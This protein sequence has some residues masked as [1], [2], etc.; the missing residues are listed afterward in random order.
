MHPSSR[1]IMNVKALALSLILI[2]VPLSGC[3]GGNG[4]VNV[5]LEPE[6]IQELID[7]NLDDFLNNTTVTINQNYTTDVATL[8]V[9]SGTMQ[10]IETTNNFVEGLSILVRGD[11]YDSASAGNSAAGLNGA[12]ICVGIGTELE[13][14]V[15]EW[16]Q[17]QNIGF[18]SVPI[19]DFAEGTQ[20][21]RDGE[22]DALVFPNLAQ[23]NE[24]KEQL[25]SDQTWS[26][27]PS[28][29]IWVS[30]MNVALIG[31]VSETGSS[32]SIS[33]EQSS[34]EFIGPVSLFWTVDMIGTCIVNSNSSCTNFSFQLGSSM[35]SE[36]PALA[37]R[38]NNEVSA[39][40]S[41]GVTASSR[42]NDIWILDVD[43]YMYEMMI[44][45]SIPGFDCNYSLNI[46]LILN[47]PDLEN[48]F[49][50]FQTE[51][52]DISWGEW[53]YSFVWTSSNLERA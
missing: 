4:E 12:N 14:S 50:D 7:N 47:T 45:S 32:I 48:S 41:N 52:Y 28:E 6:D 38:A 24:K 39:T 25:D 30:S 36:S 20:K 37:V 11:R 1:I 21:F 44:D 46:E 5:D 31:A 49:D 40:C 15:I 23:A 26:D 2:L 22:C 19:A 16:F 33:I 27:A 42:Q 35:D 17:G 13:S 3:A 18:T 10:G 43:Y 29:G 8:K 9:K 53:A 51:S 34:D